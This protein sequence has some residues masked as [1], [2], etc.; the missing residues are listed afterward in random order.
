[1]LNRMMQIKI[2]YLSLVL[3]FLVE[4]DQTENI[5]AANYK[6]TIQYLNNKNLSLEEKEALVEQLNT[7]PSIFPYYQ[8]F[9]TTA[10]LES[11]HLK[12]EVNQITNSFTQK[13]DTFTLQYMA[14]ACYCPQWV[15]ID[16]IPKNRPDLDGFYL[17]PAR[18]QIDIPSIFRAGTTITFIGRVEDNR[19]LASAPNSDDPIPGKELYYYSYK[20][21]KPYFIW[22]ERVFE[23]YNIHII[24]D[25]II[26][27]YLSREITVYQ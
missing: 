11:L 18:Y 2:I 23:S 27:N 1:M 3:F 21:H 25:D 22:G 14:Y 8:T 16:S 7:D 19:H 5:D 13:L 26:G 9:D 6:K 4:C 17:I 10:Y 15:L 12:T 20:I 24:E